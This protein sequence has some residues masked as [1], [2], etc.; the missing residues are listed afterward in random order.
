MTGSP[1]SHGGASR[2]PSHPFD[3]RKVQP[4]KGILQEKGVALE[5][6][7]LTWR[8]LVQKPISKLD[9]DAYTRVRIILMNGIELEA[10]RFSHAAAR[11]NPPGR[12]RGSRGGDRRAGPDARRHRPGRCRRGRR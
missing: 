6:Q 1:D 9:D 10:S 12:G 7:R 2:A 8:D 5:K 4:M 3:A 11:I